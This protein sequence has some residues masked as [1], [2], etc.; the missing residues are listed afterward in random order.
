MD[1]PPVE[2]TL[3]PVDP[4][5]SSTTG[6]GSG[7]ELSSS[8][9]PA[10][11][12]TPAYVSVQCPSCN[13][14]L[15]KVTLSP[16]VKIN[17][18]HCGHRF[19]PAGG[20]DSA[21]AGGDHR[22]T[23][24]EPKSPG[25]W[26]LRVPATIV[27]AVALFVTALSLWSEHELRGSDRL[28]FWLSASYVPLI[29]L[30]GLLAFFWT[31]SL[32]LL[33]AGLTGMLWRLGILREPLPAMAGSSLPYIA[34]LSIAGGIFPIIMFALSETRSDAIIVAGA[35]GAALFLI[36][37]MS[38]DLRQ[39][40]W[41]EMVLADKISPP[42][43]PETRVPYD[44]NIYPWTALFFAVAFGSF[45]ISSA[46]LCRTMWN[47]RD[48]NYNRE[49]VVGWICVCLF[50]AA[51]A[52]TGFMLGCLWDRSVSAWVRAAARCDNSDGTPAWRAAVPFDR[53]SAVLA[54]I[55][56]LWAAYGILWLLGMSF[57]HYRDF[58]ESPVS[59]FFLYLGLG[60]VALWMAR[61]QIQVTR[62]RAAKTRVCGA[63]LNDRSFGD[64]MPP[65]SGARGIAT[66]V[67][68]LVGIEF[69]LMAVLFYTEITGWRNNWEFITVIPILLV[70]AHY[71][72][73]WVAGICR[74]FIVAEQFVAR[75]GTA[76]SA[77]AKEEN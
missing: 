4:A 55:P 51:I 62:W 66:A 46:V 21:Q 16:G 35:Y 28:E 63:L 48:F 38:E 74:E 70:A 39:F 14:T 56:L 50:C 49:F 64:A 47:L 42:T 1:E 26:L 77:A 23:V 68:A 54:A 29:A 11:D 45:A 73:L 5:T 57:K 9:T 75:A 6:S 52:V 12:A 17:C 69:A 37:F 10:A 31:R 33:D 67:N 3:P 65:R 20:G 76:G 7:S 13:A 61:M 2:S 30:G 8:P 44:G 25:Y 15:Q 58:A 72:T 41:R 53:R 32:A 27:C 34:P 24:R 40:A 60:S 22:P 59:L 19:Y 43:L 18:L 36:G 71:P